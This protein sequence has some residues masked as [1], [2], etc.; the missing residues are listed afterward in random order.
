VTAGYGKMCAVHEV[1]VPRRPLEA[2]A[3]VL[4]PE[5][6][7]DLRVVAARGAAA[8]SDRTVWN[9]NS[10][11]TGGGVAEMLH[12]L[13][14]Y[15]S[16]AGIRSRWLVLDGD[17]LFFALTKRLHNAIHGAAESAVPGDADRAHYEQV[18]HWRN[19][20][21][22]Q[23]LVGARDVVILHDPQTAGLVLPLRQMGIPVIWRCH[24]GRDSPNDVSEAAWAFLR[25]YVEAVDTA[26]FSRRQYAPPWLPSDRIS[27]I[28][29]SIDPLSEKNR[30][31][32]PAD[33]VRILRH[34][35]L[36]AG[37]DTAG[38]SDTAR[39]PPPSA[40]A[41]L[42]VQVSRWDRLKDMPGVISGF[43]GA[44]VP[45][46]VHL[47][48]AGPDVTGVVDDPEG[49]EVL[50][51]CVATWQGLPDDLR[52]RVHL[53][54]VPMTDP[55][56][57]ARIINAIQRHASVVT[58]KSLA[59]GFGLTVAEAMW[60]SRPVVATAVGG[61]Q[62]QIHDGTDGLLIKHP[63]DLQAFGDAIARL[64]ADPALAQGLGDAA[65]RTVRA[66]F[67]GDRHLAQ[68]GALLESVLG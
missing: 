3:R 53:A 43:A 18:L 34:A 5:Q 67:L 64:L 48:L 25:P 45:D 23:D 46:D 29:P 55:D 36:L 41:R 58:Q 28:P 15:V 7:D 62:D 19:L 40:E 1:T 30:P 47:M 39:T 50:A 22:L 27:V 26:I 9:V 32:A 68:Y 60:K 21:V 14:G 44:P 24:I 16:D 38:S 54:S 57:N 59:E 12:A 35:G 4:T 42:V 65:Q 10:T 6:A 49:A 11:A 31:M 8:L 33:R 61:I 13:L 52:H 56:E 66:H 20:P 17:P 2:L 37:D 63:D 51:Q